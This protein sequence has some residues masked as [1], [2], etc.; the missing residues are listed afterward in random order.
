MPQTRILHIGKFY[1]PRP[2]GMENYLGDLCR[3]QAAQGAQVL[4]LCHRDHPDEP[5]CEHPARSVEVLRLPVLLTA[6]FAPVVPL[7]P[8]SLARAIRRFSP[9]VFHV[10]MPNLSGLWPGLMPGTTPIVVH[11][12]S[13][14]A[15]PD[16]KP[17]HRALYR[18]YALF[19]RRLL[20]RAQAVVCTSA[21]YRDASPALRPWR[22]KCHVLPLGLDPARLLAPS[23]DLRARLRR[24]W[25]NGRDGVLVAF[26]GRLAHYKGLDVLLDAVPR[27]DR[28]IRLV[29]AGSGELEGELAERIRRE[30]LGDRVTLAGE[31]SDEDLHGLM[32]AAD[33]FCLPSTER[34]EAFG[35]V[36]LEAMALG[37]PCVSTDI[38]GSGTGRVNR[39]DHSG[40]VVPSGDSAALARALNALAAAPE[41]RQ[42]LGTGA[43]AL[44]EAEYRIEPAARRM[45]QLYSGLLE[46][47]D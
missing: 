44:F 26:A 34:S 21:A 22:E 31:L 30:G 40:L 25:L 29:I 14:V 37:T 6:F 38:P 15:F 27:L 32:A 23:E 35:V 20:S 1:P 24:R 46:K 10:H 43:K 47:G 41:E 13:D 36:L 12:H 42:R 28:D 11:W 45:A 17:L 2:G 9:H 4:A 8:L 7:F 39:H 33:L 3:A 16:H 19:E 18:A 5:R